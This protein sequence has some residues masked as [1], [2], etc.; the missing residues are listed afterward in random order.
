MKPYTTLIHGA[1][2][3]A[4]LCALALP[5]RALLQE[6]GEAAGG[7]DEASKG[8]G[9][10]ED[11]KKVPEIGEFFIDL[12]LPAEEVQQKVRVGDPVTLVAGQC[13][14]DRRGAAA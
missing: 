2:L 10:E 14:G 11:K 8:E 6:G 3:L 12:C 13:R 7:G 4:A 5:G 9:K 1:A